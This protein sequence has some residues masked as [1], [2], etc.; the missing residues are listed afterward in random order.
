I[1]VH[2]DAAIIKALASDPD[3][4][5]PSLQ[6]FVDAVRGQTGARSRRAPWLL[7]AVAIVAVTAGL[8]LWRRPARLHAPQRGRAQTGAAIG[9]RSASVP[10]RPALRPVIIPLPSP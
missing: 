4:R 2:V 7:A 6:A 8:S 5:F 3:D 1:P 9:H 10:A